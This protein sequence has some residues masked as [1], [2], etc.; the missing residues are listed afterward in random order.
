MV[1]DAIPFSRRA[2]ATGIVSTAFSV[3]T[4]LGVPLSLWVAN[5]LDWRASFL[6]IAVLSLLFIA[7]GARIL[8]QFRQHL[9][10]GHGEHLLS[11]TFAVVRD[12]NHRRALLYSALIIFSGFTVIPYITVYAIGNVGILQ[13]QVP[14][15][16][17]AGGTA[18]LFT[19]RLIGRQADRHGK[20]LVYRLVATAAMLP[21][22]AVT[23]AGA[24]P[25]W[26][27]LVYT[28]G[29][30]I[31]VSGRMI[32]AMA[33]VTSAAQPSLRGTFMSLNGT[34]QSL[35]MGLATSLAGFVISVD[36]AGRVTGYPL[37]GYIAIA[38]NLVAI[39]FVARI[40]MHDT[41]ATTTPTRMTAAEKPPLGPDR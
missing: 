7:V 13:E 4:V 14:F 12:A 37:V 6:F 15:I 28:T 10:A 11:A 33:I 39:A 3:A 31:L 21:L 20:V 24:L 1:G 29:F 18:T 27:W 19:A 16:Y 41:R 17:L 2:T 30:F 9:A 5:W 22:L 26:A 36:A 32:P 8:P 40:R 35:A 23:H 25:L 38:A 34:T